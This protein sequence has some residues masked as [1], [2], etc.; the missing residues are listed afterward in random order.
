MVKVYEL[1]SSGTFTLSLAHG[2][3]P[4]GLSMFASAVEAQQAA[5]ERLLSEG[6]D[7]TPLGCAPW[8]A[9][10]PRR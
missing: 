8:I 6:H 7:C 5:D 3:E 9:P 10:V 2:G 1:A 4:G